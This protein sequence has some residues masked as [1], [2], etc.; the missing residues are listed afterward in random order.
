[1]YQCY[2]SPI[3]HL[4]IGTEESTLANMKGDVSD[5]LFFPVNIV[6]LRV[7][8]QPSDL[9]SILAVEIIDLLNLIF[10]VFRFI[11]C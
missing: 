7:G 6:A 11:S 2:I 10:I 5:Y 8:F 3:N 1:M 9:A 4:S